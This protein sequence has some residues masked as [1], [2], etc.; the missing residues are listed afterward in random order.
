MG[1]KK[2]NQLIVLIILLM[3]TCLLVYGMPASRQT[4]KK[5]SLAKYLEHIPGFTV[6]KS[7]D[8]PTEIYEVLDLD[9]YVSAIYRGDA[10]VVSLYI[11]YYYSIG[12]VSAAHSPLVC[13]PSQGWV[14]SHQVKKSIQVGDR[15]IYYEEMVSS[16]SDTRMLV[17]FWYQAYDLTSTYIYRNKINTLLNE[18]SLEKAEKTGID[19]IKAFY[20]QF[21][22]YMNENDVLVM[23]GKSSGG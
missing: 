20:P 16:I 9:D 6:E 7:T 3:L 12:K 13:F 23:K 11:G 4:E 10:G 5:V 8:M 22:R 1:N 18:M 21:L 19:F 17:F 15:T 2:N 14:L